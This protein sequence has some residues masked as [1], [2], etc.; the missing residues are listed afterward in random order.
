MGAFKRE[1]LD[2]QAAFA[3]ASKTL[4]FH[5]PPAAKAAIFYWE[6]SAVAGNTPIADCKLQHY[7]PVADAAIDVDGGAFAQQTAASF[8]QLT[9][10]PKMPAADATGNARIAIAVITAVMRAVFTFD[11][12]TGDETYTYTFVVEWLDD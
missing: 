11:R 8:Q 4:T 1:T 3:S 9:V 7:D 2:S 12:T 10:D 5:P 6:I